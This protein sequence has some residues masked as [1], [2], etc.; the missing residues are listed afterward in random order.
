MPRYSLQ[1]NI[2]DP[3]FLTGM[4]EELMTSDKCSTRLDEDGMHQLATICG[5]VCKRGDLYQQV[6]EDGDGWIPLGDN[7]RIHNV[8]LASAIYM[9]YAYP[10]GHYF[11]G[12]GTQIRSEYNAGVPIPLLGAKN[13]IN[14]PYSKWF[15]ELDTEDIEK[16]FRVEIL[17]GYSFR[18]IDYNIETGEKV[19]A[20]DLGLLRICNNGIRMNLSTIK[21]AREMKHN[22][23]TQYGSKKIP[24]EQALDVKMYNACSIWLRMLLMQSWIWYG[25]HRHENMICDH[26]NWD[27]LPKSVDGITGQ[28]S[29]AK[30]K[31]TSFT[32]GKLRTGKP[33]EKVKEENIVTR[34][35]KNRT[36]DEYDD[37]TI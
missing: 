37:L 5:K 28:L 14:K 34:I 21:K 11:R 13:I 18:S 7:K 25:T 17:L 20:D 6:F 10:R 12:K 19:W 26:H 29:T 27:N 22:F 32:L 24:D 2:A 36:S 3:G 1:R 8:D 31:P 15:D 35:V 4:L 9:M 33:P 23:A 16:A 30:A